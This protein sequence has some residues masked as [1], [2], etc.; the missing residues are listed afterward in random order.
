MPEKKFLQPPAQS[1]IKKRA[2]TG[3]QTKLKVNEHAWTNGVRSAVD[4]RVREAA[5][6]VDKARA[7]IRAKEG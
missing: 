6:K 5:D 4:I 2:V 3:P 1:A 7:V